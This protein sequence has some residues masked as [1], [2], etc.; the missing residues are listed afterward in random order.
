MNDCACVLTIVTINLDNAAGLRHTVESVAGQT[1]RSEFEYIVV[2]GA[3]TDGSVDI[4]REYAGHID[5]CISEPDS[6]R[7]AAMNKGVGRAHGRYVLFL[8]SGDT[9]AG[10]DVIRRALDALDGSTDIVSADTLTDDYTLEAAERLTPMMMLVTSLPHPSTFIRRQLLVDHPYDEA[11]TIAADWRFFL[12]R[13]LAGDVAYRR[14]PLQL[15]RF[16]TGGI[17]MTCPEAALAE[18]RAVLAQYMP[19][20]LSEQIAAEYG[21]EDITFFARYEPTS[22]PR[23]ILRRMMRAMKRIF[24]KPSR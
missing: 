16:D 20:A 9:L 1:A 8:N 12:E 7:Y 4:L 3:S 23:R 22:M 10:R 17:S 14:L 11:M 21:V 6:G 24:G 19:P 18:R 13:A 15:S 5:C 2:D